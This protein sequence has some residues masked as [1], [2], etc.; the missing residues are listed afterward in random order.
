MQE[1]VQEEEEDDDDKKARSQMEEAEQDEEDDEEEEE[2]DQEDDEEENED[3]DKE[4][5]AEGR[6]EEA[7]TVLPLPLLLRRVKGAGLLRRVLLRP[8]RQIRLHGIPGSADEHGEQDGD[9]V[10]RHAAGVC[11]GFCLQTPPRL[12]C[13]NNKAVTSWGSTRPG[14]GVCRDL[15][16]RLRSSAAKEP[17]EVR[18]VADQHPNLATVANADP[19]RLQC[20][21][22]FLCFR[23]TPQKA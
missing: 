6:V 18:P 13:F 21:H 11:S 8:L 7:G 23:P 14:G 15:S 4:E 10:Q 3:E 12:R 16:A 19:S 20:I 1:E 2:D 9:R 22:G 5:E 17:T